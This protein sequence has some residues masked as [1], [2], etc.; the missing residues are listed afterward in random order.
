MQHDK[1]LHFAVGFI[2]FLVIA[3]YGNVLLAAIVVTVIGIAKEVFDNFF[4]GTVDRWDAFAT[5][6]GGFAGFLVRLL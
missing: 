5:F 3:F 2:L 6:I 1:I 4:G